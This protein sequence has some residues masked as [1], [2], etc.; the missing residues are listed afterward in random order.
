M[1][2]LK[3]FGITHD[4]LV[5]SLFPPIPWHANEII[6]S[7]AAILDHDNQAQRCQVDELEGTYVLEC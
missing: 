2:S 7:L 1:C 5:V 3:T 4:P 6:E